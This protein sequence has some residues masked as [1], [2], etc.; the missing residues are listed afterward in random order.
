[1]Q[2]SRQRLLEH[3]RKNR[4]VSVQDL[5]LALQ[6]TPANVRHHLSIL[7]EQ[8]LVEICAQRTTPGGGRPAYL[9]DL[10][11]QAQGSNLEPLAAALLEELAGR[12]NRADYLELLHQAA[13]RLTAGG[14]PG[15]GSP[16][17][18]LTRRLSA[19]VRWL[20]ERHYQAR[21]EAHASGPH[22]I[23]GHCP[24]QSLP[25]GHPEICQMEAAMLAH[26]LGVSVQQEARLGTD[27]RGLS[28]CLFTL[29]A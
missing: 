29:P 4:P 6:M 22:L 7:G 27:R 8:G 26:L 28:F 21:W 20:N 12:L 1:M 10:S 2:T 3:I 17:G 23:L 24:Y 11:K 18:S 25:A 14:L 15:G 13:R 19:A 9:Y 16:G 5:S